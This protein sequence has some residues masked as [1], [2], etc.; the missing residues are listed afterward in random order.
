MNTQIEMIL[1]GGK[2]MKLLDEHNKS[3]RHKYDM[4]KAELEI[5][6]YLSHCGEKNTSTDIHHYLV[7]NRGHISQAVDSLCKKKYLIATPD[8]TDRRYMHYE[9]TEAALEM[10]KEIGE[11]HEKIVKLIL[12]GISEEEMQAFKHTSD[13]IWRNMDKL[14]HYCES[15]REK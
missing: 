12:D 1:R 15:G 4:K 13:K 5:L 10:V 11:Q 2:F 7:M 3:L 8:H 14:L 6:Y 9:L